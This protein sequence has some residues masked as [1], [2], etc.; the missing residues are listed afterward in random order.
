MET[1]YKII[2]SPVERKYPYVGKWKAD[3]KDLLVLFNAPDTGMVLH[4]SLHQIHIGQY[5]ENF[6]ESEFEKVSVTVTFN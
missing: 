2:E 4:D 5:Y 6:E 3:V 1:S